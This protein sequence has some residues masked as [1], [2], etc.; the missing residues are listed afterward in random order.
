MSSFIYMAADRPFTHPHK[1]D[2][3]F[4][5]FMMEEKTEDILTEKQ[6]CIHFECDY[7]EEERARTVVSYIKEQM[8]DQKEIEIWHIW[9]G[10]AYPPPRIKRTKIKSGSLTAEKILELERTDVWQSE[11]ILG[12]AV[13]PDDWG[14]AEDEMEV[15]TQYCYT[16]VK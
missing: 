10:A 5:I 4:R 14:I 12:N 2:E 9:M 16:I 1:K 15:S 13:V 7:E 6:Y 3:S 8:Q 11:S